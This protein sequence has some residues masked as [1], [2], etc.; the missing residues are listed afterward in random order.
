MPP[1]PP[2]AA[3]SHPLTH[4]LIFGV[5]TSRPPAGAPH[6]P[7]LRESPSPFPRSGA[8]RPQPENVLVG[9]RNA[10]GHYPI[11]VADFGLS[12][13]MRTDEMLSTACG[14]PHYVA[15]EV[16]TFD[17]SAQYDGLIS[18]VW[19]LGVML[20]VMLL[21]KLP[22]EAEST[23][24]LYKKIRQG[25][26]TLPPSLSPSASSLLL[27]MLTVDPTKCM[28]LVQV[29]QH[30]WPQPQQPR[31]PSPSRRLWTQWRLAA[32]AGIVAEWLA[33]FPLGVNLF[34][35]GGGSEN[36]TPNR[37]GGGSGSGSLGSGSAQAS[38]RGAARAAA[39]G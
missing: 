17:G 27:G 24:L 38:C 32:R 1:P 21:Y 29:V 37:L 39:R 11:K 30:E 10:E 3:L 23:Q 36:V 8:S 12:T 22:F 13:L 26:P 9:R 2:T 20:H 25:L 19:S 7:D 4:V 35:L 28:T 5:E 31:H 33:G 15:P 6:L 34:M 14:S 16:L 18:D